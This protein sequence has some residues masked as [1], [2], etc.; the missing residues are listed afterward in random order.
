MNVDSVLNRV[1]TPILCV[2]Y[3]IRKKRIK[4]GAYARTVQTKIR[5]SSTLNN[6]TARKI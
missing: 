4:G 6:I 1:H 5:F 3:L 2:Y